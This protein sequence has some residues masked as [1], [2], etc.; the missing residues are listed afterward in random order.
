MVA[1][2]YRVVWARSAQSALDDAIA[3]IAEDSREAAARVL[4]LVLET[5]DGLSTLARRGRVVP[6]VG[7]PTIRE[8]FAFRY[9]L[10]YQVGEDAVE[11]VAFLHGATDFE[12]WP[13]DGR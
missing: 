10:L 6:E 1:R 2:K 8:V 4:Q 11:I 7:D 13:R 12:R 3:Y 5:A 9:R